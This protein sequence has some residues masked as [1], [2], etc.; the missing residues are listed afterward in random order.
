MSRLRASLVAVATAAGCGSPEAPEDD[1]GSVPFASA[2]EGETDGDDETGSPG[3]PGEASELCADA[4]SIGEGKVFGSLR[5]RQPDLG[6]ACGR[7]GPDVFFRLDVPL[8]ADVWLEASGVGFVPR[9]GVLPGGCAAEWMDKSLACIEGVGGWILDVGAASS[10]VLSVG[11]DPEDPALL[12]PAPTEGADALDFVL[13]VR[14]REVLGVGVA[15]E[16]EGRGR[17]GAGTACLAPEGDAQGASVCTTLAADTCATAEPV[18]LAL[19]ATTI[20]ISADALHTDAHAHSCAGSRRPE[21]VLALS[22]P[23]PSR[24]TVSTEASDVGL[25]L[26]GPD[27]DPDGELACDPPSEG[28]ARVVADLPIPGMAAGDPILLFVELPSGEPGAAEGTGG[29]GTG[30]EA[31]IV[32][33]VDLAAAG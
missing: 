5:G 30:E 17:C 9:V 28:G 8:R 3:V 31:P 20:E 15:C 18:S 24:L 21:R 16:P 14:L 10:L 26:R 13:D 27:C 33:S 7:G 2:T 12:V 1:G 32:L 11:V 25:A 6:G 19:G 22:V 29:T 23:Q 4:P